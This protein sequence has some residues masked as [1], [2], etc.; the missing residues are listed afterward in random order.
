MHKEI[1]N[2]AH[3]DVDIVGEE[4]PNQHCPEDVAAAKAGEDEVEGAFSSTGVAWCWYKVNSG[5]NGD[6]ND[7]TR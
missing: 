1:R 5:C 2:R 3:N 4:A 6:S 7:E